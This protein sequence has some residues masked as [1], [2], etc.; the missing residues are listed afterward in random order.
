MSSA[1]L[2]QWQAYEKV[3]GPLGPERDDVLAAMT[4]FYVLRG[5]GAKR[6]DLKRLMPRW[7]R[8]R[9][10]WRDMAAMARAMTLAAGGDVIDPHQ[11][12]Q[13]A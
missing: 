9:Q 2:T 12:D 5:L 1:E 3:T 10:S 13:E 6:V 11:P 7:D 4:A 8:R